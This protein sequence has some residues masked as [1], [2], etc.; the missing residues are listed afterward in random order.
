MRVGFGEGTI[1]PAATGM[2]LTLYED[3]RSGR[4]DTNQIKTLA[5]EE[6]SDEATPRQTPGE[7]HGWVRG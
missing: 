1:T 6:C 2:C 3:T 4:S 7:P 5:L